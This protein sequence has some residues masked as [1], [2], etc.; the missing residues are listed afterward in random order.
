MSIEEI[1][2]QIYI[3]E[4]K[5]TK[6]INIS[7]IKY[8]WLGKFMGFGTATF[9]NIVMPLLLVVPHLQIMFSKGNFCL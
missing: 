7:F 6:R 8:L 1:R 9:P 2:L 5:K 3:H 4:H